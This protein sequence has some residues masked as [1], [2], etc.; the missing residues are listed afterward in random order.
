MWVGVRCSLNELDW[1]HFGLC[2]GAVFVGLL[3]DGDGYIEF[4]A[5]W[6]VH[7]VRTAVW[8]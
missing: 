7:L 5:V 4:T 3:A 6:K 8:C 2:A 1:S